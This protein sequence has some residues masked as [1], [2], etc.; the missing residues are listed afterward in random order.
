MLKSKLVLAAALIGSGAAM[1]QAPA[2][3]QNPQ[4][5]IVA[6]LVDKLAEKGAAAIVFDVVFAE[7]DRSSL[8]RVVKS[9]PA[10]D[11]AS[12]KSRY[13]FS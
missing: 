12:A 11:Q 1:A 13:W 7:P 8:M 6:K 3:L 9:L 10:S 5:E 4:I 2:E